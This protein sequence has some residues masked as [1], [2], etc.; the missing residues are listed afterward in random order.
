MTSVGWGRERGMGP[1]TK[2]AEEHVEIL[3]VLC[4]T[5]RKWGRTLLAHTYNLSSLGLRHQEDFGS[6]PALE[7]SS[8]DPVLK[9]SNAEKGWWSGWSDTAPMLQVW[10]PE[11][12]PQYCEKKKKVTK[13]VT[14]LWLLC[15]KLFIWFACKMS[16]NKLIKNISLH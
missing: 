9:V 2:R 15:P 13:L 4:T 11:F 14:I 7:N 16:I 6:R 12:K 1:S 5:I 8:G 3:E 10:S